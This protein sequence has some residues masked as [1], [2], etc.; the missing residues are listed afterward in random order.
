MDCIA[1][2]LT[3]IRRAVMHSGCLHVGEDSGDSLTRDV[4]IYCQQPFFLYSGVV[5][6]P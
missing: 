3:C 4:H 5:V 1:E 2:L 6:L